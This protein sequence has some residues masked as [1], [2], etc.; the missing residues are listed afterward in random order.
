M[1]TEQLKEIIGH[2]CSYGEYSTLK[3]Q[4]KLY[5]AIL[6]RDR[7]RKPKEVKV[8]WCGGEKSE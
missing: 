5:I 4:N 8:I 1:A 6:H 3:A 7:Y 2:Y